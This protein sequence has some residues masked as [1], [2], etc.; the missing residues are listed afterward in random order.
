MANNLFTITK[1]SGLDPEVGSAFSGAAQTGTV[2]SAV[3]VTTRGIDL[4]PQYPQTRI[5]TAG[6]DVNF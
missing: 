5:Y 2:G 1:Y 6:L 4:V 3:G